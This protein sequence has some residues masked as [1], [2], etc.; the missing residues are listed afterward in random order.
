MYVVYLLTPKRFQCKYYNR[1]CR[2][3]VILYENTYVQTCGHDASIHGSQ[4]SLI[5]DIEFKTAL[6]REAEKGGG[7]SREVFK[8]IAL[9]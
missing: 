6:R 3:R 8:R 5:E 2:S 4:Q 1:G 9:R 7:E